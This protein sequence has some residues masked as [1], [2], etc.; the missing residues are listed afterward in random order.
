MLNRLSRLLS[1]GHGGQILLTRAT[2][3]LIRDG[4]PSGL[5]LRDLGEVRLRDLIDPEHVFQL[6]C[7]EIP[8]DFPP[9]KFQR[10][11][12]LLPVPQTPFVGRTREVA[13]LKRLLE[14]RTARLLTLVGPGGTGKTRLALAVAEQVR[15]SFPDGVLFVDLAVVREP[16]QVPTAIRRVF[17]L[18]DPDDG[19]SPIDQLTEHIGERSL[20]LILD[21]FEHLAPAKRVVKALLS[22]CSGLSVLVTSRAPL[23]LYGEQAVAVPPLALPDAR[24]AADLVEL[25]GNEAV[26]LFVERAGA[27]KD[28]F[29]LTD[30]N[31]NDVVQICHRLD[32]LP[33]A[34]ELAAARVKVLSPRALRNRL[35]QRLKLLTGDVEDRPERHQ[36]LRATIDWS[37][38][39]LTEEEQQLFRR[40]AVFTGGGGI[41]EVEALA[42]SGDDALDVLE[43]LTSLVDK[44]LIVQT[45]DAEGDAR[46][47]MLETIREYALE[48]LAAGDEAES[49]RSRHAEVYAA[50]AERGATRFDGPDEGRWLD[51]LEREHGNVRAALTT[52]REHGDLDGFLRLAGAIWQFWNIRGYL[53]EG[54]EWLETARMAD[55]AVTSSARANA[56]LGLGV[57]VRNQGDY[58]RARALAEQA[59]A[60]FEVAG[61]R[62]GTA[63]ALNDLAA[64]AHE[65]GEQE[66][67]DAQ[68]GRSL[69]L[70]Q[71]AG[72]R[73]GE[74]SALTNR[75]LAAWERGDLADATACFEESLRLYQAIRHVRGEAVALGNLGEV[76]HSRGE[77]TRARELYERSLAVRRELG[78]KRGIAIAL[79]NLVTL[80][81]ECGDTTAET[82]ALGEESIALYLEIGDLEGE[83]CSLSALGQATHQQG[84]PIRA[85][86]LLQRSLRLFGELDDP[87]GQAEAL[88]GLAWVLIDMGD[89]RR[90]AELTARNLTLLESQE[91]RAGLARAI[92]IAAALAALRREWRLA[93]RIAGAAHCLR[94]SSEVIAPPVQRQRTEA[95]AR[96][97]AEHLSKPEFDAALADGCVLPIETAVRETIASLGGSGADPDLPVMAGNGRKSSPVDAGAFVGCSPATR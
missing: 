57:L 42:S 96:A 51:R 33:L 95:V 13:R 47:G 89:D 58:R 4:L 97:N 94:A 84:D 87:C 15:A 62:S 44:S 3:E 73:A 29:S 75:G 40:L 12:D 20:L 76:A 18:R 23:A 91:D 77:F 81:A 93:A 79:G 38:G 85:L 34:I 74:A 88:S 31:A 26:R 45:L 92:E 14:E 9:L 86:E 25:A 64:V 32:G 71:A 24:A 69:H 37:H 70:F 56:L 7:D 52:L 78:D 2:R 72:D 35:E 68:L 19:V 83:A 27:M 6:G 39:L 10:R 67:A 36:T 1:I 16:A 66:L 82:L 46:Y 49:V 60:M 17:E 65:L 53:R 50:L 21:N 80:L 55:P 41:D 90:A 30:E 22:A 48:R 5:R 63:N 43:T 59:L 8:M 28:G 11:R 61:D 54:C